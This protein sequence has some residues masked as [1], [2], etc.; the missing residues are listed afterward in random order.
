M[1]LSIALLMI[2]GGAVL[3]G[4]SILRRRRR[5]RQEFIRHLQWALRD[6]ETA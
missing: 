3:T 2:A 1:V 6:S 5:R 4:L